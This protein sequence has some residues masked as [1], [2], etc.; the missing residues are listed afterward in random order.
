MDKT[1]L[2]A[3]GTLR[4]AFGWQAVK[5]VTGDMKFAGQGTIE[6]HLYDL[7]PYPAAV[8]GEGQN[9]IT[10]DLYE[11]GRVGKVFAALDDYEGEEYRRE[12]VKVKMDNG[13]L[14]LAFVYWYTG[15]TNGALLIEENDYLDYL[16][17]KKDRFE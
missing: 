7:G 8:E 10:G 5:H 14:R 3:Y 17:N 13:E 2:F 6:G 15:E 12:K 16:K 11:V 9:R 4:Q 1:Y